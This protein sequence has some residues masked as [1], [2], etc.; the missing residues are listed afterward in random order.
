[1]WLCL[2]S[3]ASSNLSKLPVTSLPKKLTI[4]EWFYSAGAEPQGLNDPSVSSMAYVAIMSSF[5]E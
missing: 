1:M 5:A 2:L 4:L 3:S